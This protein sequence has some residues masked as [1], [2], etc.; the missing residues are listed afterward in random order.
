MRTVML[1]SVNTDLKAWNQSGSRDLKTCNQ[2]SN[3]HFNERVCISNEDKFRLFVP[4]LLN[5]NMNSESLELTVDCNRSRPT[6]PQHFVKSTNFHQQIRWHSVD[7]GGSMPWHDG[8]SISPSDS[9]P[10]MPCK[11]LSSEHLRRFL[12]VSALF[13]NA[14]QPVHFSL[15]TLSVSLIFFLGLV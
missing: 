3:R 13:N 14:F 1:E 2:Y 15:P 12:S 11:T 4:N 9:Q 8:G 10:D 7:N 5:T 6:S